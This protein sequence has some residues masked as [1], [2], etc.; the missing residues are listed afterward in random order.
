MGI[1]DNGFCLFVVNKKKTA[2]MGTS[3]VDLSNLPRGKHIILTG[4][5]N[6]RSGVIICNK[7][8]KCFGLHLQAPKPSQI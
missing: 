1:S 3:T 2:S 6:T 7:A 5:S 4:V 8:E